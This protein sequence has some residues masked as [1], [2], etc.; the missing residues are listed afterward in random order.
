ML[1]ISVSRYLINNS[2]DEDLRTQIMLKANNQNDVN[3][4]RFSFSGAEKNRL[5]GTTKDMEFSV[6]GG[7][8]YEKCDMYNTLLTTEQRR[9]ITSL[10]G[11]IIRRNKQA[12]RRDYQIINILDNKLK[13][14]L[15]ADYDKNTILGLTKD[16]EFSF[17]GVDWSDE[18]E[19][20]DD[21]QAPVAVR[22]KA[23]GRMNESDSVFFH[24][25]SP[26]EEQELEDMV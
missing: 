5:I 1:G 10:N 13:P 11:I 7:L 18:I 8:T 25:Y 3:R 19:K 12:L 16:M 15:V 23:R 4:V 21:I 14:V 2:Y 20:L 9:K 17:D 6:D 26:I 22:Y 24:F